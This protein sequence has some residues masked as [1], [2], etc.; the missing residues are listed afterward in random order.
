MKYLKEMYHDIIIEDVKDCPFC[1]T[2]L[3]DFP[4]I[5]TV[6]PVYTDEYLLA[7]LNKGHFLGSDNYFAVKC[8]Q[9]GATGARGLDRVEAIKNWNKRGYRNG[10]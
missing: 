8:I 2:Q 6:L 4:I 10:K 9:C 7:K 5:M 1:G 3:S